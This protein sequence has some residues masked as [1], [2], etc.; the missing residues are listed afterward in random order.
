MTQEGGN[1]PNNTPSHFTPLSKTADAFASAP[2]MSPVKPGEPHISVQPADGSTVRI[3]AEGRLAQTTLCIQ[4][5]YELNGLSVDA[6]C[7]E[8]GT[9]INRSIRG[10]LLE[11]SSPDYIRKLHTGLILVQR[12]ILLSI[13]LGL[14]GFV[15][16]L[17]AP[18]LVTSG[19]LGINLLFQ[20]IGIGAAILSA[21]G[22]WQLSEPDPSQLSTNKGETP[23]KLIRIAIAAQVAATLLANV[24]GFFVPATSLFA[25]PAPGTPPAVGLGQVL[26]I[27][28][29][30]AN[31]AAYGLWFFAA[32]LYLRWLAARIPNPRAVE[33]ASK[34]R[35]LGPLLY[36]VGTLCVGIGPLIALVLY[37]NLLGWIRTDL[38]RIREK[39]ALAPA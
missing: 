39:I 32:M 19:S 11:F 17:I 2:K 15:L 1:P 18:I 14:G 37:Y 24:I 30:I 26:S 38:K 3:D 12:M 35:W 33:R 28:V 8:C 23:R 34:L 27:C 22:W 31:L 13:I 36:T 9:A 25:P 20:A 6:K 10:D 29:M 7:P 5:G 21:W 16:G 4:C